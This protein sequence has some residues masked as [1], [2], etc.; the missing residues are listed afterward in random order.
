M[1]EGLGAIRLSSPLLAW[2]FSPLRR[3][4][5][6]YDETNRR[7]AELIDTLALVLLWTWPLTCGVPLSA[8]VRWVQLFL[9]RQ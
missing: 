1:G 5:D 2:L 3:S 6:M 7:R 8:V 4:D 9:L